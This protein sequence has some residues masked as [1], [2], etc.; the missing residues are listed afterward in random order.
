MLP[1]AG[2][3]GAAKMG[4]SSPFAPAGAASA[5]AAIRRTVNPITLRYFVTSM[6]ILLI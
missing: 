3:E 1:A 6:N 4:A 2:A 5:N